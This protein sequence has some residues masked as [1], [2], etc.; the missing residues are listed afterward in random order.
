MS[1]SKTNTFWAADLLHRL[2]HLPAIGQGL[3]EHYADDYEGVVALSKG[4]QSSLATRDSN[5]LQY[6]ALEVY[7][8]D[9]VVKGVGCSG[10]E[11]QDGHEDGKK[12]EKKE[13]EAKD[14][15]EV[16]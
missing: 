13:E 6:F 15:P 3:I 10:E 5:T 4:N 11:G 14:I 1:G 7:A 8:Y 9:V 12:E 16:G 2:Y